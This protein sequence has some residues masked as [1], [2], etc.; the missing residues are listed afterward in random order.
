MQTKCPR[1]F[2]RTLIGLTVSALLSL[3]SFAGGLNDTLGDIFNGMANVTEPGVYEMQRRGVI[4]GGGVSTRSK[5]MNSQ[6]ATFTPP[7]WKSGCGGIDLYLGSFSFINADQFIELLRAVAANSAGYAFQVALDNV[8][9]QCVVAMNGLQKAMQQ[10]NQ[11][12]G[13]SCQLAKGIVTEGAQQIGMQTHNE[14]SLSAMAKGL[15]DDWSS[16]YQQTRQDMQD[17]YQQNRP[18]EYST[19]FTGNI[20]WQVGKSHNLASL[21][22]SGNGD[23][24]TL[25][26]LMSMTGTVIVEEL[27]QV[28]PNDSKVSPVSTYMN[29]LRLRDFVN[30]SRGQDVEVYQCNGGRGANECL[31]LTK[32]P[33]VVMGLKTLI[34]EALIGNDQGPGIISY[35]SGGVRMQGSEPTQQQRNIVTALPMGMGGILRTLA[36]ANESVAVNVA[37][38][39]SGALATSIALEASMQMIRAVQAAM[40]N[41]DD[42]KKAQMKDVIRQTLEDL[43][44]DRVLLQQDYGPLSDQL[45]NAWEMLQMVQKGQ[46]IINEPITPKN[47]SQK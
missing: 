1:I 45:R 39:A 46:L 11:F 21:F 15:M 41:A 17:L 40:I 20:V 12:A 14:M 34:E 24:A 29:I 2:K 33:Q 35:W 18:E 9:P 44:K 4:A 42:T 43:E 19:K 3:P 32:H 5:I 27:K 28:D 7:S 23:D 6:I 22:V 31:S 10:L 36:I 47:T 8:C 26:M 25:E 38:D 16:T 37:R 13:N 30:G